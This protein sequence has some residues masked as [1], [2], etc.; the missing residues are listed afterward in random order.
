MGEIQYLGKLL[1]N[2]TA[3]FL[4][5]PVNNIRSQGTHKCKVIKPF[6]LK[7]PRILCCKHCIDQILRDFTDRHIPA[8]FHLELTY[9]HIVIGI[10]LCHR[11]GFV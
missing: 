6:V 3:P 10:N 8:P 9:K 4:E 1:C 11:R 2:C 7:K 5:P